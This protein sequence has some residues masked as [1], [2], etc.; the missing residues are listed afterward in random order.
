MNKL[1]DIIIESGLQDQTPTATRFT[2]RAIILNGNQIL[3][4]YSKKFKDY[5]TPG[6]GVE[7]NEDFIEA[8]KREL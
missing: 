5:M 4:T 2:V 6:G 1:A 8:L 3:M 7:P